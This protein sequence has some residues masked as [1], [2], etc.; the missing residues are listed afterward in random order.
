MNR[1]TGFSLAAS[2]A[3]LLL[4]SLFSL[5]SSFAQD[6]NDQDPPSRA[7]RV[8]YTQ[9]TV[10]F[11]PGGDGDWLDAVPNRPLTTGDNLWSDRDSRA[12][13]QIG[14]TSV[15]LG[16]ETSVTLLDLQS[17][18][19]QLRVSVGTLFFRVRHVGSDETFEV[20]TPNLAFNVT[21]PGQYRVDVNENGDQTIA[22]V[23]HGGAEI[24]GG[25][26][27]YRLGDGQQ[28]TFSGV[29]QLR[30][31]V[32][33]IGRDDDFS[34]W[35]L[36]RDQRLDRVRS[37]QYVSPEM[38]GYEDLDEYGR[39]H[40]DP[41]YGNVWTPVNVAYDWAPYRYGHW[42]FV[43]PWGWT[44][45]EDEPWGFAPFHYGRWAYRGGWFWVPGP[46]AV[47]PCYS[48]A[49]VAFVG[50]GGFHIGVGIGGG[51]GWFPLGPGE[52]FVP[53]YR[54]SPRYVQNVNIT[55]TRVTNIQ[56][57]NVYNNVT[58]NH[59]N[60][61]TYVN[62]RQGRGITVVNQQTFV[63]ARPVRSNLIRVDAR[64]MQRAPVTHEVVRDIQPQR[65]SVM[66]SAH[67]VRFAPPQQVMSRPVVTTRQPVTVNREVPVQGMNRP[68]PQPQFRKVDAAPRDQVQQL[69]R[70]AR[71]SSPGFGNAPANAG[72]PMPPAD[73]RRNTTPYSGPGAS[74]PAA[75]NP[76]NP[77]NQGNPGNRPGANVP[78]PGASQN[79]QMNRGDNGSRGP[80]N[81]PG[82]HSNA[83]D[84]NRPVAPD[85]N[86]RPMRDV[87]RP[88]S[89]RPDQPQNRPQAPVNSQPDQSRP[90]A[91]Y[92]RP[93][94]PNTQQNTPEQARPNYRPAPPETRQEVPA[95]QPAP[96][97]DVRPAPAPRPQ[98]TRPEP[99]PQTRR[100]NPPP[101]QVHN[102]PAP[103][104][105]ETHSAPPPQRESKPAESHQ[106][107]KG[108]SQDH[109]KQKDKEPPKGR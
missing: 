21:E 66:G 43:S 82:N 9:G 78:R 12:E 95:Q 50:G 52:V 73:N 109:S 104:P 1:R 67:P 71:G 61:I 108:G 24:T 35:C 51:V 2:A 107:N 33:E 25:G 39:W 65:Q 47:V 91:P 15:R 77:G 46:V 76:G 75:N 41:E 59:V 101:P 102:E 23:W 85:N 88:P 60:N 30:Y 8:G 18:V 45:V 11:Q 97:R 84:V 29:D 103:R 72:R 48:P 53:W 93:Q 96:Q 98:E 56:V 105:A 32:G 4:L 17:N 94:Q 28:G 10:S 16:S 70:G 89:A 40:S 55:N 74:A 106:D 62:Q 54:T 5:P 19:T 83:P 26:S 37:A 22:T 99:P 90:N 68:A 42:V 14:S 69:Q 79:D 57:T 6:Q 44:W 64:E 27:S 81:S 92:T 100:D 86:N 34:R 49:L 87:P 7:G 3:I 80:Q 36:E 58:V 13:V 20:D 63:N 31:D 38:T